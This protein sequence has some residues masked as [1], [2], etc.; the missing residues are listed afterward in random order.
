VS[1]RGSIFVIDPEESIRNLLDEYL[2]RQQYRIYTAADIT[3]TFSELRH[4]TASVVMVDPG[5]G[6]SVSES[7]RQLL[8]EHPRQRIIFMTGNPTLN[9]I[10]TAFRS[11]AY[12]I[13]VKPLCPDDQQEVIHR[14]VEDAYRGDMVEELKRR[15]WTPE[16]ELR[17]HGAPLLDQPQFKALEHSMNGGEDTPRKRHHL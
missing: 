14:A 15:I 1:C 4:H 8:T 5:I 6:S 17:R 13:V 7:I 3:D 2:R 11:G 10:I 9:A 16:M 12:D